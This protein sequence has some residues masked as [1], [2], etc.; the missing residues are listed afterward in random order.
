MKY[1]LRSGRPEEADYTP[2]GIVRQAFLCK[3]HEMVLSGPRDTG[4]TMGILHKLS[5]LAWK[6]PGCSIVIARKQATDVYS[7][8]LQTFQKKVLR[9]DAPIRVYGGERPAWFDYPNGSRIWTAG[10]DKPGK[11]LSAEHD[12]IYVNQCEEIALIDW[13]AL[14]GSASGRAGHMPYAQVIGDC[15]PGPPTHWIRTRAHSPHNPKGPLTL[16]NSRHQDNPDLYDQSTMEQTPEGIKRLGVLKALTGTRLQRW[17]HGLW[18]APEGAIY[19]VFDEEKHKVRSRSIPP[20]HPRFVGIDPIGAYV[21]AVW[22]ALDPQA[23]ILN[24]Y[25]EYY[26][27]FGIPTSQH[28]ANILDLSGYLANGRPKGMDA[29]PVRYWVCGAPS[30]RQQRADFR[31]HGLPVSRPAFSDVW[32]GIDRII[33]LLDEFSIVVH[34][35]CPNLLSQIGDYRRTLGRDGTPTETIEAKDTYHM[36]DALRYAVVGPIELAEVSK[37]IYQPTQI[38]PDW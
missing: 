30:E 36:L 11:V 19:S 18:V 16:F 27:P 12:I 20:L 38:G 28:V 9:P 15:N 10:L 26:E 5:A 32:A 2:Y 25:R 22:V 29:E 3:D 13:E 31:S 17:Y 8:V 35:S 4:K 21:A 6:Y 24:V 1:I 7:T 14:L 34:D 23:N 33:A 37:V